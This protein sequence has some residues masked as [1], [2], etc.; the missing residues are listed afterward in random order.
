MSIGSGMRIRFGYFAIIALIVFMAPATGWAVFSE[1]FTETSTFSDKFIQTG[2]SS[3]SVPL[4]VPPGRQG[5]APNLELIYSSA[6]P[7]GWVGVGWVLDMGAIQRNTRLGLDYTADDYVFTKNARTT[8]LVSRSTDWGADMYGAKIE[9]KFTKYE[10]KAGSGDYW[11]ATTRDGDKY[12]FGQTIASRIENANGDIFK[13]CLDRVEDSNGNYMTISYTK[14]Q[15]QI[16][17]DEIEYAGHTSGVAATNSVKFYLE[18]TRT[19]DAPMY[20][21]HMEVIT[22]YRLKSVEMIANNSTVRAYSFNYNQPTLSKR[23][24]L[25]SIQKYGDDAVLD[26]DGDITS[27]TSFPPVSMSYQTCALGGSEECWGKHDSLYL[28]AGRYGGGYADWN[29]DGTTEIIFITNSLMT[30]LVPTESPYPP[31]GFAQEHNILSSANISYPGFAINTTE[32]FMGGFGDFNGDGKADYVYNRLTNTLQEGDDI[33]V[34]LSTGT[35]G[36]FSVWGAK[37]QDI[38]PDDYGIGDF[39]GDGFDDLMYRQDRDDGDNMYVLVSNGEDAFTESLWSTQ[40]LSH[41]YG[42]NGVG[43]FNGDGKSDWCFVNSVGMFL[44]K[45]SNGSGFEAQSVWADRGVGY[46]VKIQEYGFGDFNG[47]GLT[48]YCWGENDVQWTA[49]NDYENG[50][51]QTMPEETY[52]VALSTGSGFDIQ[53]WATFNHGTDV[54]GTDGYMS[55]SGLGDFNGDGRTDLSF[56]NSEG[57]VHMMF[58]RGDSFEHYS[59]T[60][61][62]H[63]LAS[64]E[65]QTTASYQR[66][67]SSLTPRTTEYGIN[68]FEQFTE[69]WPAPTALAGLGDFDGDGKTDFIYSF[70]QDAVTMDFF[71]GSIIIEPAIPPTYYVLT[72]NAGIPD[73]LTEV[74]NGLGATVEYEYT[75]SSEWDN[76]YLP[77][78]MQN[79]TSVT[80]DDGLGNTS[81]TELSYSGGLYD[82]VEREFRGFETV[83]ITN[84][85]ATVSVT[86]YE[87]EDDFLKG[88][89]LTHEFHSA[90]PGTNTLKLS[91]T[92]TWASDTIT[93]E[94]D[95][96]TPESKFVYLTSKE[97]DVF[98]IIGGVSTTASE[99]N[100]S[101]A[102]DSDTGL[103]EYEIVTGSDYETGTGPSIKTAYEYSQPAGVTEWLWR[104]EEEAVY[105]YSTLTVKAQTDY[106][107]DVYGNVTDVE[108]WLDGGTSPS[109]SYTYDA[110]GNQLTFTDAITNTWTTTYDAVAHAYPVTTQNPLGHTTSKTWDQGFG[111]PLTSTDANNYTTAFTYDAFGRLEQTDTPD[112]GTTEIVYTDTTCP[113][114]VL[115]RVYDTATSYIASTD[116][117]DGLGRNIQHVESTE[118]SLYTVSQT[119]YDE[120]GRV[121]YQVG[122]FF[123]GTN[124]ASITAPTTDVHYVST[125]YD[126][127]GRATSIAT[128]NTSS[129]VAVTEFD[130][131]GPKTTVTNPDDGITETI[132]DYLGR[133]RE[134]VEHNDSSLYTTAYSYD[135]LGQL[136]S[137]LDDKGNTISTA[138]DT[139]GRKTQMVHPDMGTWTYSYDANGNLTSQTDA[140]SQ[141]VNFT[142]DSLNRITQ[143]YYPNS[144]MGSVDYIYD[145]YL[146]LGT[147]SVGRLT[148]VQNSESYYWIKDYD[149]MGRISSDGR[150]DR[151]QPMWYDFNYTYDLAGRPTSTEYPDGMEVD[152]TY[153]P[154]TSLWSQ[155]ISG[156]QVLAEFSGYTAHGKYEL[157]DYA[158]GVTTE[159]TYD[160]DSTR[161]MAIQTSYGATDYQ[162]YAYTYTDGGNIASITDNMRSHAYTYAYDDLHRLTGEAST[163]GSMAWTYDAIGNI[164]S[165][166]QDGSSMTYAYNSVTHKLDTVTAGGTA[167]NYSYDAN[168]NITA[169]P[170]LEG[171]GSISATLAIAYNVDNMPSQVVKSV[172]GQPDVTTNFYYDGNGARVRKEVVGESTT[173]YAGSLY[174]VKNGV[175]TKYIFGAD[176]RIAKITDGEGIQYFSK[177]HLGSSTVVTDDSG[178]VVEQA[179]Y[180]PFGEDRFYTGTVAKPTPYKYTDQELDEST[181]L[182][183][184]DARHYD[185]AI[186]RFISPDSLIPNLYDPQQL[187]PYA[188]C[189]NNPLIYVDPT[190][191]A[192][193]ISIERDNATETTTPGTIHV[194]SDDPSVTQ[195]FDGHTLEHSP[196]STVSRINEGTYSAHQRTESQNNVSYNPNRVQLEGEVFKENGDEIDGAQLHVGNEIDDTEGCVLVGETGDEDGVWQSRSA[197]RQINEIIDDDGSGDISVSIS[198]PSYSAL[199]DDDN[200]GWGR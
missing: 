48:D 166:S 150:C 87:Q 75:P 27:G 44:V 194:E 165:K 107:H 89:P 43:D 74:D 108:Y 15:N 51:T 95:A 143:K 172:S 200:E 116:Y 182:Y 41:T 90:T 154:G 119:E 149:P 134:I 163:T 190:G 97:T 177:D 13:W 54:Y 146:G 148:F 178:A 84:P 85:D 138:Y 53:Q 58:S 126:Y 29:G 60:G 120:M 185:P 124:T 164:L 49:W 105:D 17:L 121:I 30:Y 40:A 78:L 50:S 136:T 109:V 77:F 189:R 112:G 183:N 23:S 106:S 140:K 33:A 158:N 199:T 159:H 16:Y 160:P 21:S 187:N 63:D 122:P 86:D 20:Q 128:P 176:R 144:S 18:D 167:Y 14:D 111:A 42:P 127:F 88:R 123:N 191:H 82:P 9:S 132:L 34:V 28:P 197:M 181:G 71:G 57:G 12:Y 118:N 184:Y 47:D 125:E 157:V 145:G 169:C 8:E 192:V 131:E 76:D 6:R 67:A 61:F 59:W 196:N 64:G 3:Y 2:A 195:T 92:Y 180:R 179:D 96:I 175:A 45:L 7:N 62:S 31:N 188:Y 168:G 100:I 186:G 173:F 66:Y 135:V 174:E 147:D 83:A 162:N 170:K 110:Y 151:S 104:L 137:I 171:A 141:V 139:L 79:L 1:T 81:T 73:L 115:T 142:Y 129:T 32:T 114:T 133:T 113:R 80:V 72:T 156:T 94:S 68:P 103:T 4:E 35:G 117:I 26:V 193:N 152:Y 46:F 155:V 38:E 98:D 70:E 130:Y 24:W 69:G 19:D 56:A 39:N 52:Y 22:A 101:Y 198:N 93:W 153:I 99:K 65:I 36:S 11:V 102:H 37:S 55:F 10:F 25:T 5:M 161:L 91:T